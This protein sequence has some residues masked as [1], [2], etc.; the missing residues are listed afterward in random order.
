MA[1]NR[2]IISKPSDKDLIIPGMLLEVKTHFNSFSVFF[3]FE[4]TDKFQHQLEVYERVFPISYL[5][6]FF[7]INGEAEKNYFVIRPKE[8]LR[9]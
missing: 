5:V 9:D 3:Q 1:N 4:G 8:L 7:K 6:D 2:E